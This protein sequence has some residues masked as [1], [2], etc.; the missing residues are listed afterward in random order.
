MCGGIERAPPTP[1]SQPGCVACALS[2]GLGSGWKTRATRHN[3][4][5]QVSAGPPR[6]KFCHSHSFL[7]PLKQ[8]QAEWQLHPGLAKRPLRLKVGEWLGHMPVRTV[9]SACSWAL[10]GMCVTETREECGGHVEKGWRE[11]EET[12]RALQAGAVKQRL[13]FPGLPHP[14]PHRS[15]LMASWTASPPVGVTWL[16]S[17]CPEPCHSQADRKSAG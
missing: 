10:C 9:D 8:L 14:A 2:Q 5:L 13:P 1:D 17:W 16:P 11:L 6:G 3:L 4:W 15:P 7:S 12:Q